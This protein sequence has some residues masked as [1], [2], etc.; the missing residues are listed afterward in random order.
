MEVPWRATAEGISRTE[1]NSYISDSRVLRT[2]QTAVYQLYMEI[3]FISGD[4]SFRKICKERG[5]NRFQGEGG[6][7][8]QGGAKLVRGKKS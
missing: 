1:I 5:Q 3:V 6:N 4:V 8:F 2:V 7:W